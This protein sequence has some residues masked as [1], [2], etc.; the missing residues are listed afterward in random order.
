MFLTLPVIPSRPGPA[1][2]ASPLEALV[3][4]LADLWTI[5]GRFVDAGF[6]QSQKKPLKVPE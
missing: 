4:S 1:A 2:E 5:C 3:A 6:I